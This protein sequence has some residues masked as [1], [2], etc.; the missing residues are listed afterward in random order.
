ME[1]RLPMHCGGIASRLAF[2]SAEAYDGT[3]IY[4]LVPVLIV[5]VGMTAFSLFR[6][7]N[8]FREGLYDNKGQPEGSGPTAN[9][10]LQNKMMW[11]RIKYQALAVIVVGVLLAMSK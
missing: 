5:L 7:L 11:A 10:L 4:I 2:L 9:Q 8:A 1:G 3:M 6:G